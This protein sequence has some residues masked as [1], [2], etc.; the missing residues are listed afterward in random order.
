MQAVILQ[1]TPAKT[2]NLFFI[3]LFFYL[4]HWP[5]GQHIQS[6]QV[7]NPTAHKVTVADV[8]MQSIGTERPTHVG[9]RTWYRLGLLGFKE[10][11]LNANEFP[12]PWPH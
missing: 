4:P 1:S 7:F 9:R 3:Y 2:N 5:L 12:V 11:L 8:C 10:A 6:F